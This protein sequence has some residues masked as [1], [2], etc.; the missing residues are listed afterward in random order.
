MYRVILFLIILVSLTACSST[1][2]Q[3][4]EKNKQSAADVNAQLAHAYIRQG[5]KR[6]GVEKLRKALA[7]KP[8]LPS[9]HH[10]IAETY[11][12]LKQTAL[13]ESHYLKAIKLAPRNSSMQ[14][15]YG[16][17]LCGEGRYKDAE[18][19]FLVSARNPLYATPEEAYEN[20]ALCALRIPDKKRAE[21]YFRKA[22]E[23]NALQA[24]SLYQLAAL[25]FEQKNY[26]QASAFLQ[27]YFGFSEETP[28]TLW[29]GIQIERYNG[30]QTMTAQYAKALTEKFSNSQEA[31]WYS[32]SKK[33]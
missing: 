19:R 21:Y 5:D 3:S 15:N 29:L 12:L 7:L 25:K 11:R 18:K 20:A 9:T 23:A 32:E 17:F 33:P 13:A 4:L 1:V 10:Y 28:E 27:R 24:R 30:N 16:V 31:R 26:M 8:T 2:K 6:Q 22:L 14:N